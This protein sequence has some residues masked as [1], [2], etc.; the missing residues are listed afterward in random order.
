MTPE[1]FLGVQMQLA[2]AFYWFA[3]WWLVLLIVGGVFVIV[4]VTTFTITTD[5]LSKL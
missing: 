5:I 4:L 1:I 2:S 3:F